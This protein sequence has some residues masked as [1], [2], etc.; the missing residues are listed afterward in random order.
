VSAD[1]LRPVLRALAAPLADWDT[2]FDD[3]LSVRRLAD[4]ELGR[5]LS[6]AGIPRAWGAP[7]LRAGDRH[8]FFDTATELAILA[9][10]V[11]RASVDAFMAMP[12]PSMSGVLVNGMADDEQRAAYYGRLLE[13]PTWTFFALTEPE[14]G[15]DATALETRAVPEGEG[16][17]LTGTKC[18]VGNAARAGIGVAFARTGTGPLAIDAFLVD[19]EGAGYSAS[20]MDTRCVRGAGYCVVDF[21]D[22]R[23]SAAD[24]LGRHLPRSRRGIRGALRV[25][26]TLRPV[27]AAMS[28]G[29]G[30]AALDELAGHRVGPARAALKERTAEL[31]TR[32]EA[33]RMLVGEAA[34]ASDAGVGSLASAAKVAAY[35]FSRAA[36][37]HA[38]E[39]LGIGGLAEHH[40]RALRALDD[41]WGVQF[42]EGTVDMQL[43]HV[44][45]G[46]NSSS[47]ASAWRR[48]STP[49]TV[50]ASSLRAATAL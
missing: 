50:P 30:L 38:A 11:S 48:S 14:H 7:G 4:G 20:V 31:Q 47:P 2:A 37:T 34:A 18:F 43:L 22:H 26:H 24:L 49:S 35:E 41:S 28:L 3:P 15:S 8:F 29:V 42:M 10:E 23:V 33:V 19:P 40:P 36:A 12:G 25:F 32:A 13:A 16:W 1:A 21:R 39:V 9:E 6:T 27:V 45:Q 17:S 44:F 5:I 46:L